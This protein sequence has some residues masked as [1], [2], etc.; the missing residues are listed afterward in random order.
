MRFILCLS[1]LLL[2]SGAAWRPAEMEFVT[3]DID[4]FWE[5][6]DKINSTADTALQRNYLQTLFFDRGTPGLRLI[7]QARRYSQEEYLHA[8]KNYPRYWASIRANT[9]KAKTLAKDIESGV[10]RLKTLYPTLRPAKVY[11]TIGVFRTPGTIMDGSILIGS[12]MALGDANTDTSE[13][14]DNLDY[15]KQYLKTN[16]AKEVVFLNVHEYVHTQ[17][18]AAGGYD[19]LSQCLFEGV[20]EFIATRA[21][22]QPSPTPAIEFGNQNESRVK[23]YFMEE[24]FSPW[25]YNWIWNDNDNPFRMRDLGYYIGYVIAERHYE[26]AADK[27]QAICDL[28]ELDYTNP[29]AVER[30]V[31]KTGY[32]GRSMKSMHRKYEKN[33][34]RVTGIGQF[35]NGSKKIDPGLTQ[36]TILFSEPMNLCCRS[37]GFGPLGENH[38]PKMVSVQFAENGKSVTY[39]VQLEPGRHYQMQIES[40]YRNQR[41]LP[42]QPCLIDFQTAKQ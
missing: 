39:T 16:P 32:F 19:L 36:I 42:L 24:M 41:D 14:P 34:P 40:G 17:Q 5:A 38:I 3:D 10:S 11:F 6:Y 2:L 30:L 12:E 37:T 31:D 15:V 4:H 35:K 33:R 26:Q 27:Q 13:L 9:L 25:Y 8:I 7:M 21:M 22:G 20:A 18:R 29:E 1:A 28:I 23:S